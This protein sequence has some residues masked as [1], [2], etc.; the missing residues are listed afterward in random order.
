[1]SCWG[2]RLDHF[3][4]TNIR[5]MHSPYEYLG[6]VKV[7]T[8][9]KVTCLAVSAPFRITLTKYGTSY[10]PMPNCLNL[11]K[12]SPEA[13]TDAK[14]QRFVH[15]DSSPLQECVWSRRKVFFHSELPLKSVNDRERN[16]AMEVVINY[17]YNKRRQRFASEPVPLRINRH[18]L[19]AS[20]CSAPFRS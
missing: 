19:F 3:A 4:S 8:R 10:A 5:S 18:S 14:S 2:P 20:V 12:S 1:M 9:V 15:S 6:C 17:L 16:A 11:P 13:T 7:R